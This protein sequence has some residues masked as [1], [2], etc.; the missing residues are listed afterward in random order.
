MSQR[1]ERRVTLD[2]AQAAI[3]RL[4]DLGLCVGIRA[5]EAGLNSVVALPE[6]RLG[7][8]P[9][10]APE[11]YV[12]RSRGEYDVRKGLDLLPKR[13]EAGGHSS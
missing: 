13:G 10:A 8:D 7:E 6:L 9:L 5:V 4:R 2:P 3:V 1:F 11:F 12:L